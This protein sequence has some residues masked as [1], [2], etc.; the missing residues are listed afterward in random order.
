MK[1]K[2]FLVTAIA[3]ATA[4][5]VG[6]AES[7]CDKEIDKTVTDWQALR[8]EPKSKPSTISKGVGGHEHVQAAV[9]SMRYHLVQAKLL[10]KDGKDH[11]ALLHIDVIRAFLK[12]PEIQHP[13]DHRYLFQNEKK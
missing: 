7:A 4:T 6:H 13:T 1:K 3:L 10:C 9:D 11:E 2:V 12:L 5:G 8:L